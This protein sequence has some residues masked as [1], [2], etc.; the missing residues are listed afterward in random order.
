ML[1]GYTDIDTDRDRDTGRIYWENT[2]DIDID[3]DTVIDTG[4]IYYRV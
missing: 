1:G 3:R 2:T 4:R